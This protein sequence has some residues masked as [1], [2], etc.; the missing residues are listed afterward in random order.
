MSI[1]R[2]I[3][4]HSL[5]A[6]TGVLLNRDDSGMA[7][8]MRLGG[9]VRTRVS[10]QCLKR[11]WRVGAGPGMGLSDVGEA[12]VRTRLIERRLEPAL[13][14]AR[15]GADRTLVDAALKAVAMM[16]YG[17]KG[18]GK[19]LPDVKGRQ[20]LLL[21]EREIEYLGGMAARFVDEAAGL[22]AKALDAKVK[23]FVKDTKPN[24]ESMR[25]AVAMPGGIPGALFGRMVTSDVASNLDAAISVA[26]S[27]TVHAQESEADAL[28][29]VDDLTTRDRDGSGA[30]G[31]FD[32]EINSGVFYGY[33]VVDVPQL[34]ANVTGV[35]Q[36]D[37]AAAGVDRSLAASI[38]ERLVEVVA[39]VSP[40]AKKGSTAPFGHVES[41]MVEVG[42]ALPRSL[43]GAFHDPVPTRN[44]PVAWVA[45][46]RMA[47]RATAVDAMLGH[48]PRRMYVS[49]S[50][51]A[52][53]AGTRAKTLSE[54][55]QFASGAILG[56]PAAM[57][58]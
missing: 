46:D 43:A 36:E 42:D 56:T 23:A 4:I 25:E 18:Y 16:L 41:M 3:Q 12:S 47:E 28:T 51:E 27:F 19:G 11:H 7:K 31:M 44:R 52:E 5:H 29:V 1:P 14:E 32:T 48:A 13:K 33:V 57:A 58:A 26:H 39:T 9:H 50:E 15:P 53:L 55:A 34:V 6:Y 37:F 30:G 10:S 54:V 49:V 35:R 38:V 2:F 20:A 45:A 8:R 40:G 21:G 24:M 17:E 22:D